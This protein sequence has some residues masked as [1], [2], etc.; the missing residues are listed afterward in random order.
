MDELDQK[1]QEAV[2][3]AMEGLDERVASAVNKALEKLAPKV[4][5]VDS[6]EEGHSSSS[7][8]G[9]QPSPVSG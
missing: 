1:V 5:Q 4:K 9:K 2:S 6:S 3:K 7:G 8:L